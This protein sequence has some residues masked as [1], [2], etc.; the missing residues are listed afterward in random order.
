MQCRGFDRLQPFGACQVRAQQ[1]NSVPSSVSVSLSLSLPLY[2]YSI[3]LSLSIPPS[4]V[5]FSCCRQLRAAETSNLLVGDRARPEQACGV[6]CAVRVGEEGEQRAGGGWWGVVGPSLSPIQ[7]SLGC[8]QSQPNK[9]AF[10][11]R[12]QL[13]QTGWGACGF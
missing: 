13:S 12:V 11:G 2:S 1:A 5:L 4:L 3:S 9:K 10:I 8:T 7:S 6:G